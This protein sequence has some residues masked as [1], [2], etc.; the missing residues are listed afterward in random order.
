[1]KNFILGA[2]VVL[3]SVAFGVASMDYLNTTNPSLVPSLGATP[4]T[5]F[6]ENLSQGG[7]QSYKLAK[8]FTTATTTVC[9]IKSP[10]ATSTLTFASAKFTTGTTTAS[11]VHLAKAATAF[12]TTTSL[13]AA[14]LAANA[15]GTFIA[16]STSSTSALDPFFVFAPNTYF[17]VGM[18]GGNGTFSPVGSCQASFNIN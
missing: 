9:A 5:D 15:Q 13:G 11:T 18:A 16:S 3:A 6:A 17:V 12:A 14:A 8:G 4:G 2:L 10:S 7:V 1:M